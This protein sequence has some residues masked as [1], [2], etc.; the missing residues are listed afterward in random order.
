MMQDLQKKI[1]YE[2]QNPELLEQALTHSSKSAYRSYERLEFLGD[3]V[4]SLAIADLLLQH[5]P[6]ESEGDLAKRHTALVQQECLAE[7][8]QE[9]DIGTYLRL[10]TS[11]DMMGGRNKAA[12]LADVIESII[13]AVHR[14]GGYQNAAHLIARLFTPAIDKY[15][16]PPTDPKTALQEW[17]QA[18]QLPLPIYQETNVSGPSHA[19][20]FEISVTVE[21]LGTAR[22]NG[23]SKK[24]AE[25]EAAKILLEKAEQFK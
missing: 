13:G 10:S 7:I 23:A 21:K 4:L 1:G 5:F 25:K 12:I 2:F 24:I 22:A 18:R 9:L 20:I 6:Q 15:H 14:D 16:Q 17:A 8:A 19:P 11:E 3:R